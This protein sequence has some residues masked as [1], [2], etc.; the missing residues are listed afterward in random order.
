MNRLDGV[1]L[2]GS[3]LGSDLIEEAAMST[4]ISSLLVTTPEVCGGRLRIDGTGITVNQIVVLYKQGYRAEDIAD[5]YPDL[6]LAQVYTALAHYHANQQE[7]EADLEAE[8][9]ETE[10]Q[11]NSLHSSLERDVRWEAFKAL[12]RSL[13]LTPEKAA[14]WQNAIRDARR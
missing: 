12:Q 9:K 6:T 3:V 5:E 10:D 11:G 7:I 1:P 4:E 14:A 2:P 8:E 13:D